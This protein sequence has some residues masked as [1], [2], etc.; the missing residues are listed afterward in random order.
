MGPITSPTPAARDLKHTNRLRNE[1][2]PYLLQHAHNPVDWYA[3]GQEAFDAAR[4]S[5]KPIFLSIGY[6][7]CYW[8][9]VMERE[10]FESQDIA[11]IMNE[12]FI[13]IKVD[14][15]ERPDVDDIY[16][17]SVQILS[18]HGG[19]PMSVFLEP[20]TLKPF[21]AGTY[22]PPEDKFGRPGFPSVLRHIAK[23]WA[24]QRQAVIA[25]ADQVANAV[26]EHLSRSTAPVPVG[27]PQVERAISELLS[28]YDPKDAGFVAS[29]QRA[30]KFPTPVFL[31]FLIGAAWESQPARQA[32]IQTLDRMAIGGMYDQIGGG[33]HRYSTDE[34]W[35]VPHFEK[36]L[37]D[38]AQLAS[39]YARAHEL[40]RDPYYAQ[41][42]RET[43]DYVLR[44]MT[45]PQGAFFSAQDAEVDGHEGHNYLWNKENLVQVLMSNGFLDGDA[46]FALDVFGLQAGPN[47]IDP[48]HPEDG[49]KNVLYLVDKPDKIAERRDTTVEDVNAMLGWTKAALLTERKSRKPPGTDDKI[50]A[51]WN[52]LMIAAMADGG[53]VLGESKYIDAAAAAASFV[54]QD[55]RSAS[56]GLLRTS[57]SGR[58]KID[59]FLEDYALMIRGLIAL[60]RATN[61]RKWIDQA[62]ELARLAKDRFWDV[63]GAGGGG[64]FDTLANQSDLFVRTKSVHDGALPAGN[65]VML[66]NLLDLRELTNQD[67]Y[68]DDAIAT[69]RGL[70]AAIYQ[71]PTGSV[72]SV[73]GLKRVIDRHADRLEFSAPPRPRSS[74]QAPVPVHIE[75]QPAEI[76]I[77]SNSTARFEV[78]LRIQPPYHINAHQPSSEFL[79]P[80]KIELTGAEGLNAAIDYPAGQ[81]HEST[82]GE[83]IPGVHTGTIA[84][85]VRLTQSGKLAGRPHLAITYQACTDTEC[86]APQTS[87]V[88]LTIRAAP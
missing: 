28:S 38:N 17:A 6:S 49:R 54:R 22:F 81:T 9:H 21:T 73:L 55:M 11:A 13:C 45:S 47:F 26:A 63:S 4:R 75:I 29:P 71:H 67:G 33:F 76:E 42:V 86:L 65:S 10:S 41:I 14:R 27:S 46:E 70:S 59:A 58:A 44:E 19:W 66:L 23:A 8:C 5:N 40:T 56:G 39:T 88:P 72:L 36:M 43:L 15:E 83:E 50:L 24:D 2:S 32:V 85:P 52:G 68:R 79:V 82:S 1:S 35:L 37:Y 61:D 77:R 3:W 53:R 80:L 60:H 34:K 74:L 7:T 12:H 30:P 84:I 20:Q 87:T 25:Q 51:G 64:Y 48:H 18:G 31:D 69:L 16:M 62:T 78:A 57:C